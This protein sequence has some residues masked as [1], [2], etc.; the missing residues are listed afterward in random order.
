[1]VVVGAFNQ[2][3]ALVETFSVI[4]KLQTSRRLVSSTRAGA[5]TTNYN[6]I[7][8][9]QFNAVIELITAA[10]VLNSNFPDCGFSNFEI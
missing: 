3:K 7:S 8:I 2:E 4:V 6:L 5:D 1:M 10:I 9:I